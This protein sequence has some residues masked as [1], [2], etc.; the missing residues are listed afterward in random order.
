MKK[1]VMLKDR[2]AISLVTQVWNQSVVFVKK[3]RSILQQMDRKKNKIVQ[4][5]A[6]QK[7][8]DMDPKERFHEL[9]NKSHCLQSLFHK[10][11]ENIRMECV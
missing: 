11:K 3:L 2:T 10:I 8:V 4:Y 9:K 5:F 7:F 6:Y 1:K